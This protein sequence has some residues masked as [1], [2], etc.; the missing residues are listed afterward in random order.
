MR[1]GNNFDIERE[2]AAENIAAPVTGTLCLAERLVDALQGSVVAGVD[3]EVRF[4]RTD[5]IGAENRALDH[6]MR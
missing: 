1:R 4:G 5:G 2:I 6:Q 3:V